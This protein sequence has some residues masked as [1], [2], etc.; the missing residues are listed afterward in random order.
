MATMEPLVSELLLGV[1][2]HCQAKAMLSLSANP[3]HPDN[4]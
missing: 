1:K 2:E 4:V 3:F